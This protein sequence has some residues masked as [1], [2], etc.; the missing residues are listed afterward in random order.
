MGFFKR[1]FGSEKTEAYVDK[2]GVYFYVRCNNCGTIV[3]LRADKQ[4]DLEN[5]D[6]GYVWHKTIV[7]SKCFRPMPAVVILNSSYELENADI[8][9]GQFVT[10]ADYGRQQKEIAVQRELANRPAA[11]PTTPEDNDLS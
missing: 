10:E 2:Q 9:G 5:N 7:D 8:Q 6:G 3:R 1:L 4:Y 11:G